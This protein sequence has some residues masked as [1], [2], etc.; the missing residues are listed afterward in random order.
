MA[1][2]RIYADESGKLGK[3]TDYTSFCGYI[4]HVSEWQRFEMEWTNARF[5]WQVPALHMSRIMAPDNKDDGWLAI[6]N[7]WGVEWEAKR[8][9]TLSDFAA[10]VLSAQIVCVGGVVDAAHFRSLCDIDPEFK[11]D[12]RVLPMRHS[13]R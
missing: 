10:T 13:I 4:A 3:S 1:T 9:I 11:E 8:T 5:R 12:L 2:F 6:K 7:S